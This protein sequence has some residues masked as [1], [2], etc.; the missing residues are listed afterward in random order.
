[1]SEPTIPVPPPVEP[2]PARTGRLLLGILLVLL[3]IAW[4]LEALDVLEVPWDVFLPAALIAVGGVLVVNARTGASHR[5]L[6]ALGVVLTV[7]LMLTAAVDVPIV[8]G[9]GERH[10]APSSAAALESRYDLGV[11]ELTLDL[12]ALD[13]ATIDAPTDVRARVGI[14]RLVVRIPSGLAVRVEARAGLGNVV[15]FGQE[16]GGIDVQ[17]THDPTEGAP[18]LL[19]EAT[20][21][22]GEVSVDRG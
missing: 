6:V 13:P 8:G 1:M 2:A 3:G 5:G 21:G 7:L 9:V 19:L 15:V 12:T 16:Q 17:V 18:I 4:L 11:G 10:L 20:V 22:I 14:G